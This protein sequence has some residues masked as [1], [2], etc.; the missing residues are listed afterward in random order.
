[1]TRARGRSL[2]DVHAHFLTDRYVADATAA[3]ISQPDG[4]PGW[5]SWDVDDHLTA[6]DDNDIARSILSI[7]SPG[8]HFGDDSAAADLARHVN[9]HAAALTA[10]HRPRFDFLASL[11]LPCV[12]AATD[13]A[14][15]AMD[16]LGALGVIMLSNNGSRYLGDPSLDPLWE[17]LDRR[18]AV[19]LEH[20][21]S[22][23]D[24]ESVSSGRPRPMLEFMFET[25]RTVTDL[26]SAR[27]PERF[28]NIRFVIPH[29]GAALPV[30][31]DR[32]ELFRE[33]VP[34]PS[35][36]EMSRLTTREQ[37]Q[38]LSF[39][40][41]GAAF[42]GHAAALVDAV[43]TDRVLYGS[44]FCWTPAALVHR[45]VVAMDAQETDWRALT[46]DNAE[47]LLSR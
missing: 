45:L 11:P 2:V 37:L 23:P 47:R 9:E 7:S 31:M 29:C 44:D 38:R 33:M 14:A 36:R 1:M 28:P 10:E 39:D 20:P 21:T 24:A 26:L 3:G 12:Q 40:L 32:I 15:Y 35:G 43:G 13:E 42:P 19:V 25:T 8:V 22:P 4:M 16:T 6:M 5:P 34:N 18:R 46:T 17:A 27:V 30:L 41:A